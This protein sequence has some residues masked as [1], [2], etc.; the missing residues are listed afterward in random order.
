MRIVYSLNKDAIVRGYKVV[1]NR[2]LQQSSVKGIIAV[3]YK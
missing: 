1:F 2:L 3:C